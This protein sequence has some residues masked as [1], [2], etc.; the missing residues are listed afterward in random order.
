MSSCRETRIKSVAGRPGLARRWTFSFFLDGREPRL[1]SAGML[2][3]SAAANG[4]VSV[5]W[6]EPRVIE[7]G[8]CAR[9]DCGLCGAGY[10]PGRKRSASFDAGTVRLVRISGRDGKVVWDMPVAGDRSGHFLYLR[11]AVDIL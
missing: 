1:W 9:F 10:E 7:R 6:S 3:A 8:G 2:A 11:D 4:V 5:P